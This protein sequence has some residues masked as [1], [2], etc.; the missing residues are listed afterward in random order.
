M[1]MRPSGWTFLLI[2]L[3]LIFLGAAIFENQFESILE[4]FKELTVSTR[5]GSPAALML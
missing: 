2:A 1:I 3:G 4:I 5:A